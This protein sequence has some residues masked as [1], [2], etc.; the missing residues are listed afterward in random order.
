MFVTSSVLSAYPLYQRLTPEF[1]AENTKKVSKSASVQNEVAYFKARVARIETVDDFLKDGRLL[2]FALKAYNLEDQLQYPARI[3]QIMKDDPT[4]PRALVQRMTSPGYREINGAFEFFKKGLT[5]LKSEA[6]QQE[7]V[8]RYYAARNVDTL[9]ETSPDLAEALYFERMIGKAKTGYDVLGD[10]VLFAVVI[11][12]LNLPVQAAST[13]IERL[14]TLIE[15]KLDFKRLNEPKY[16]KSLV[17]RYLILKDVESRR[18]EG[19][20]LIDMFA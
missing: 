8:A 11:K 17:E 4:D 10:R 12:A 7:I 18:N 5:K 16:V 20:G 9:T 1:M 2:R 19:G 3:K 13:Q 6:F 14:K 15:S